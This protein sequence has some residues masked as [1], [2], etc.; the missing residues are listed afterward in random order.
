MVI[1]PLHL[2]IS[3]KF[4]SFDCLIQMTY[5][6]IHTPKTSGTTFTKVLAA[7]STKKTAFFYP[8]QKDFNQF[9]KRI[10]EGPHY[11]LKKNPDWHEND[12]IVGHFTYGIHEVFGAQSYK[13]IGVFRNPSQHY[14]S[15]FKHFNR[16]GD[17]FQ[18]NILPDK[19]SL[20]NLMALDYT[21]NMQS[22]FI[23]GLSL[24]EIRRDKEKAFDV[25]VE[26]IERDFVGLY[27]TDR[28]IEGMFFFKEKL[29]IKLSW[30]ANEN[31][32]KN[33]FSIDPATQ[34]RLKQINDLDWRLYDYL[35]KK[36]TEE[37][38]K[39][40]IKGEVAWHKL[41]RFLGL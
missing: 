1:K 30:P 12:F 4:D 13:Y 33:E 38:N 34:E 25:C 15:M 36:F 41:R 9:E 8:Q 22:F 17:D 3:L 21:H 20:E 18:K 2:G 26:N 27:P 28:F 24:D 40:G 19:V 31:V 7:D 35:D 23:S 32:S 11:H 16:M 10:K 39:L 6:F 14:L 29:G 37:Y 5:F